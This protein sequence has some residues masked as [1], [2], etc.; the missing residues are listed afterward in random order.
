VLAREA[1]RGGFGAALAR[2]GL[3]LALDRLI[4]WARWVTPMVEPRRFDARFFLLVLPAG[5][6][7]RH[8]EHETTAS[9]W[10]RPADILSR[11]ARGEI[12]LA[13]PTIHTL[14]LLAAVADV[15]G[16]LALAAEQSLLPVCPL[17]VAGEGGAS[18]FL[19]LPGDE[20]HSVRERRVA[21]PT[22][23][24]IEGGG[25]V[26]RVVEVAR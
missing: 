1:A 8:D 26:G 9:F 19:A 4:P 14:G 7:G 3:R 15:A 5:Q 18:P 12:F 2:R 10:A 11:A 24:V 20:A 22:R 6:V 25:F 21:G 13:P 17:F 23:Y 16:A